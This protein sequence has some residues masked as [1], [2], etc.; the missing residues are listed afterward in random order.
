VLKITIEGINTE[1][2]DDLEKYIIKKIGKLD[3][4]IPRNA[5]G[6][7]HA[8]VYLK[9]FKIKNKKQCTCEIVM[10]LP[11]EEFVTKETTM[12]I[13]AAVDIVETKLKNHLRK[14][15]ETHTSRPRIFIFQRHAKHKNS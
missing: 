7:A 13:F 9:E 11:H 5:R 8:Q 15:K 14:Y 12:N 10:H 1:V 2:D 6:S 3:K 4:Y